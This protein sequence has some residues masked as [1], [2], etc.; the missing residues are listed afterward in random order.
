MPQ[1]KRSF[2]AEVSRLL[3]IVAHSLYSE[4]EIFLRELISNASDACDRLRYLAL[5]EPE[6]IADDPEF[7][8]V[9]TP[10]KAQRTLTIADNGIGMNHDELVENLGTIAR[11][12]TAA[13]VQ[14]LS[15]DAAQ[16]HG[17]DRP[18]RRR[19]LFRLHG[20]RRGR[21]G[22]AQGRR[23]AGAGAGPPT[24]RASSPSSPPKRPPAAP[25]ITLHLLAE[26]GRSIVEP[27]RLRQIVKTYSDHIAL[28]IL[29]AAEGKEETLNTASALWT[30][31]RA[32]ITPSSTSE[33]YHH[34]AHA[35]DEPWL[36]LH[37]KAEGTLEYT[38][39]LFVPATKPFDLFDPER[40]PHVKLYVRRVFIT[41]DC[42]ELLPALSALPARRRRQRGSAA[43]CQPRDAAAQ[44]DARQ[45]ARP[46][47]PARALRACQE[48]Q[49]GAR[50]IR[51][52]LG[53]FRR[54]AEGGALRG[55]RASRRSC[56]RWCGSAR[57]PATG[58]SRSTN[59]WR[60]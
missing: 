9:L 26:R 15:G 56:C 30:R 49:G 10:D 44:S 25:R 17:A 31:P 8:V 59:T 52:V 27:E 5:T 45:D 48:G 57:P 51:Q 53:E 20:R 60:G 37:S 2:Q 42:A 24:A 35:F 23:G 29:L 18:V 3:D 6:L 50:G 38:S 7:Q 54:G 33:F 40:K 4:K 34:V 21:G 32:E 46:D 58:S 43:Q 47:H 36:T 14:Q 19:L 16:G 39:L 1:E 28:P 41:D 12:G 13:F 22:V 55:S 11:S